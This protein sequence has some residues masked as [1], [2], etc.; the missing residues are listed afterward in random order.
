MT[1]Q[2]ATKECCLCYIIVNPFKYVVIFTLVTN[3]DLL[4]KQSEKSNPKCCGN[5]IWVTL[6]LWLAF[7]IDLLID[8]T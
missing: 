1:V 7:Y 6:F 3:G 2:E 4:E 5:L 8:Y